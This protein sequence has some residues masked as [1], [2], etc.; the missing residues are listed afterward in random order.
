MDH[1]PC[2]V[3]RFKSEFQDAIPLI[4]NDDDNDDCDAECIFA[5]VYFLETNV[6]SIGAEAYNAKSEVTVAELG[7]QRMLILNV[8]YDLRNG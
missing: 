4:T 7:T 8:T 1:G 2:F 6:E 5:V 3:Q